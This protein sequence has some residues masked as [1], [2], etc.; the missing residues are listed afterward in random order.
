MEAFN[1]P[2]E[3][4]DHEDDLWNVGTR[5]TYLQEAVDTDLFRDIRKKILPAKAEEVAR[6]FST[7]IPGN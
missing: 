3:E 4:L 1:D 2:F 6:V 7:V 5:T